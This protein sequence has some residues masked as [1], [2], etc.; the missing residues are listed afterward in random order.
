MIEQVA[1][2]WQ[3][4][5]DAGHGRTLVLGG[6]TFKFKSHKGPFNNYLI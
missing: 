4:L 6:F 5:T 2:F 1:P 3:I